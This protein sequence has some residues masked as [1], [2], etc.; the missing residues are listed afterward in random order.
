MN[1]DCG[2][3]FKPLL[4]STLHSEAKNEVQIQV[5]EGILEEIV[6]QSFSTHDFN[7][8]SN[9]EIDDKFSKFKCNLCSEMFSSES[10]LMTHVEL[11]HD[12]SFSKSSNEIDIEKNPKISNHSRS[13]SKRRM[14]S[15]FN[16]K[17]N[18]NSGGKFQ[19]PY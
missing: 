8:S 2:A 14:P 4:S 17:E 15:T 11:K 19:C 12:I 3:N 13:P 1:N 5:I 10:N 6:D 16:N 18:Y 7:E 9:Y